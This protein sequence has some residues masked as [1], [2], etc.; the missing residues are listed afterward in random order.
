MIRSH[1]MF[2]NTIL[3]LFLV[4]VN[5]IM[6]G[7]NPVSMLIQ[8]YRPVTDIRH[9]FVVGYHDYGHALGV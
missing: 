5:I 7:G 2:V 9:I 3:S 1:L 4:F 6:R 8:Y